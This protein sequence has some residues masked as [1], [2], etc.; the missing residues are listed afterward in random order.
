MSIAIISNRSFS[1]RR[2]AHMTSSPQTPIQ[3]IHCILPVWL[4]K[5]GFDPITTVAGIS[6]LALNQKEK[7][8]MPLSPRHF[9]WKFHQTELGVEV[10]QPLPYHL[11]MAPF[12]R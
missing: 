1:R 3:R 9:P 11:A 6:G 12:G 8:K 5:A 10:L 2:L 7:E 4:L